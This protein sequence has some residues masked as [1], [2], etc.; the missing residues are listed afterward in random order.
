MIGRALIPTPCCRRTATPEFGWKTLTL[1][2][3]RLYAGIDDLI[4]V[5]SHYDELHDLPEP[6]RVIASTQDCAVQAFAYGTKAVWGTQFHPEQ[7]HELGK[8]MLADNLRT[9]ARA[10]ELFVDE[11]D[12]PA[13]LRNNRRLFENFFRATAL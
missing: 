13:R 7:T 10:P 1:S 9:E 12:N 8:A 4:A 6:F 5:H 2:E 11:L 3:D